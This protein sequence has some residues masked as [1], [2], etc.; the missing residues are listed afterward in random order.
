MLQL[1]QLGKVSRA[2]KYQDML[3]AIAIDIRN[4]HRKRIQRAQ[5]KSAMHT[6]L[7]T[8]DE[9]KAYLEEQ[10]GSYHS[11]IDASMQTMQGRKG[12][13]RFVVPFS[14]QWSHLRS[15]KA[16]GGK[17]PKFGSYR[18]GAQKLVERGVLT[19]VD[20]IASMTS[21]GS[22]GLKAGGGPAAGRQRYI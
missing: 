7:K 16:N 13:K 4:K 9:K 3:N 18:Y 11:Y 6:T 20:G 21:S 5:E 14:Q 10:I 22:G 8:L 17:V 1:E 19:R 2:N 15:L 12:K